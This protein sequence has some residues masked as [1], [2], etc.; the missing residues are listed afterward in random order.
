[1]GESRTKKRE[2]LQSLCGLCRPRTSLPT[3]QI[4]EISSPL[5]F[6]INIACYLC[7]IR[8][9]GKIL[10]LCAK[11]AKLFLYFAKTEFNAQSQLLNREVK[12]ANIE[13]SHRSLGKVRGHS[14]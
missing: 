4:T 5:Q 1:M 14:P 6:S 8:R 12:K 10:D 2:T 3:S 7:S 13:R 9:R 11:I